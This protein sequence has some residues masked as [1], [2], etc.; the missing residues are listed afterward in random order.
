M[1]SCS[2]IGLLIVVFLWEL[3]VPGVCVCPFCL[4]LVLMIISFSYHSFFL[5]SLHVSL[6]TYY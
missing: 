3:V 6:S 2:C 4:R 5:L 1:G